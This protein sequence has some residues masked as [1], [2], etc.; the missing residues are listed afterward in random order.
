MV[1]PFAILGVPPFVVA[2]V[3]WKCAYE[4]NQPDGLTEEERN[5]LWLKCIFDN[6]IP[7]GLPDPHKYDDDS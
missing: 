7:T 1:D 2:Y 3:M 5:K 6:L 4:V